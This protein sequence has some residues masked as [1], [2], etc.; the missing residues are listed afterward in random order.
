MLPTAV[1]Q[2]KHPPPHVFT[3]WNFLLLFSYCSRADASWRPAPGKCA[4]AS[5]WISI[6]SFQP[7][8]RWEEAQLFSLSIAYLETIHTP[9]EALKHSFVCDPQ[10]AAGKYVATS[11]RQLSSA[12]RREDA[13]K[14]GMALGSEGESAAQLDRSCSNLHHWHTISP[15]EHIV[16]L[17]LPNTCQFWATE[18]F[19]YPGQ[20]S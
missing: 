9:G 8:R 17:D 14:P 13:Q 1:V 10:P 11:P 20:I 7:G 12:Q 18:E 5:I 2:T 15:R 6:Q 16:P 4:L 19:L 3:T